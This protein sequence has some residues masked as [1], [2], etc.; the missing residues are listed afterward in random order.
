MDLFFNGKEDG[1]VPCKYY[2]GD[3]WPGYENEGSGCSAFG[4]AMMEAAGISAERPEWFVEVNIPEELVGGK[5]NNDRRVKN[6][7]VNNCLNGLTVMG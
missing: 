6:K 7:I 3:F 1:F 4:L 2:G 5:F